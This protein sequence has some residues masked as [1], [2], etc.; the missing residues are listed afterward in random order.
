MFH[1][2]GIMRV[3]AYIVFKTCTEANNDPPIDHKSFVMAW[4]E[5]MLEHTTVQDYS[6]TR[7]AYEQVAAEVSPNPMKKE[8]DQSHVTQVAS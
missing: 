5:K 8:N 7:P 4:I 2:L 3:N 1:T 6:R